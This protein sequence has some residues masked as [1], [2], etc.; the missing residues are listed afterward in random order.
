MSPQILALE[1][2]LERRARRLAVRGEDD[3]EEDGR[4][5]KEGKGSVD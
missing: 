2:R 4:G 3:Q 1:R 5:E